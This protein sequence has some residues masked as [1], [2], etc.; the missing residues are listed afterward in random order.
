MAVPCHLS[1]EP[2]P[3]A[4]RADCARELVPIR[5]HE[6]R[7]MSF[8]RYCVPKVLARC[9]CRSRPR[10]AITLQRIE[11]LDW[12]FRCVGTERFLR[13]R[14]SCVAV[15]WLEGQATRPRKT[16]WCRLADNPLSLSDET[17]REEPSRRCVCE[18]RSHS[19][20]LEPK[21][22]KRRSI[23]RTRSRC[24]YSSRMGHKTVRRR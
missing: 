21:S 18:G 23:R 12:H 16:V 19:E 20:G 3:P 17:P 9:G 22:A 4:G 14:A 1:P 6:C 24:F 7:S 11:P 10:E 15:A 2:S 5:E 13:R 8:P